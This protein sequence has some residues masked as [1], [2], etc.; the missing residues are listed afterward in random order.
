MQESIEVQVNRLDETTLNVVVSV[1]VVT[2]WNQ[3]GTGHAT[4][5]TNDCDT[6][7]VEHKQAVEAARKAALYNAVFARAGWCVADIMERRESQ[8]LPEWKLNKCALFLDTHQD[9]ICD[10]MVEAGY[11]AIDAFMEGF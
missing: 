2:G 5:L 7:S 1:K 6:N 3:E 10:A 8:E 11:E 4:Y 9:R